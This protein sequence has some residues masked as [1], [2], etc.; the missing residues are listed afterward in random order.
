[1]VL[2]A[3]AIGLSAC[4]VKKT[5]APPLA[6]PSEVGLSLRTSIFPDILDPDGVSQS[7]V[8]IVAR[9]PDGRPMRSVPL[10]AEIR[11]DGQIVDFGRLSARNVVTG[12]DGIARLTYTS[13]P[14]P[15][16][17]VDYYTVVTLVLT[18]I[19][20]DFNG[21]DPRFVEVRVVPRGVIIPPN[22]APRPDFIIT[23][24]PVT[25]F[26][27]VTFDA[28][29]TTDEGVICG[30]SCSYSWDFGD[31]TSGSGMIAVHEFKTANTFTVRLSVTDRRNQTTV[32]TKTVTVTDTARP[33]ADFVFSPTAPLPGQN[34]FFNAAAS[35]AAPGHRIVAY[36]WDF[37]SGRTGSGLTVAKGYNTAGTYSVTLTVTDD[38]FQPTGIGVVTKTVTVGVAAP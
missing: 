26:T 28:S 33:K 19:G 18:P 25:T 38:T 15:P 32:T 34:I 10:R 4:T 21:S 7:A 36:D 8:E 30:A 11:V 23:P 27:P 9:G 12:E 5:E 14:A 37:G 35:T 2:V 16:E 22:G 31:G 3:A 6:G 13:P 29:S 1:M 17:P 24:T 20:T